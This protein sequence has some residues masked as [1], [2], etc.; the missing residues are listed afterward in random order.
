MS[1]S[2]GTDV[3]WFCSQSGVW[4]TSSPAPTASASGS[5]RSA[6]TTRTAATTRTRWTAV[7]LVPT[8]LRPGSGGLFVPTLSCTYRPAGAA[9]ADQQHH[10]LHRC[11]GDG[12]VRGGRHLL[13]VPAR[14]LPPHEGRRRDG[15][16]RLRGPRPG[17]GAARIRA[18]PRVAVQLAAG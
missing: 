1:P 6:T 11:R 9:G 8:R 10:Q 3:F 4:R 16:Q 13:R 2:S 7:S 18:A 5:T 17:L 14:P 12:A 15:R